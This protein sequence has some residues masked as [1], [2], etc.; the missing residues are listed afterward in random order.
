MDTVKHVTTDGGYDSLANRQAMADKD[1]P[2]WNM[3]LHKGMKHRYEISGNKDRGLRV[4][5]KKTNWQCEV[6]LTPKGDRYIIHHREGTKR[7]MSQEEVE[8]YLRLQAHKASQNEAD[9][10][11]RPNVESTIHQNFHRLLKRNKVKYRGMCKCLMYSISRAYW[12]NFRRILKNELETS[13]ILLFSLFR[14]WEG[15]LRAQKSIILR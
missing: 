8:T 5:C 10:N 11:I 4:Y 6:T 3:A 2:H 15:L 14:S 13:L 7:Y 9:I 1:A 12:C